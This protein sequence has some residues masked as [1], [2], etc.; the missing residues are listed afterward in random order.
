M[1]FHELKANTLAGIPFSF[2][3]LKGKKVL[4]VNTASACGFTPQYEQLQELYDTFK[5]NNF[6][7]L[8]F[9]CNQFGSQEPGGADE[10]ANFCRLNYGVDFPLME[11]VA[12]KGEQ[13][14]PVFKWLCNK[15]E[16]GTT[17]VTITWNFQKFLVDEQGRLVATL[18]PE[19]SPLDEKIINWL[20]A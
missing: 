12:V 3:E 5:A 18:S 14:H 6:V 13:I 9:P 8:A 16:N 17:D 19:S 4:V 15:N 7:V 10:I 1:L 11:K 20:E 2:S